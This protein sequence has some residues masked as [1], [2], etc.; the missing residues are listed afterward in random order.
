MAKFG[1][2][3]PVRRVEDVR[4]ITGHG[5]YTDDVHLDGETHAVMVRAQ[6]AHAKITSVDIAAAKDAPGVLAVVTGADLEAD[7]ANSV[8]CIVP[9]ENQDG[10]KAAMPNRPVLAT[11]K[12]RYVGDA[13]AMVVAETA[14]QARD[15]AEL[16]VVDTET[17]PAVADTAQAEKAKS[18][19]HDDAPGNLAF[20]WAA[21]DGDAMDGIFKEAKHV[22]TLDLVNNRLVPHSMEPR[23]AIADWDKKAEKL[24]FYANT[25]GGWSIKDFLAKQILKVDG[26]KVRV[27]TPD[28]GGGFGMKIF[29]YPEHGALAWA[30]RKLGRPIRWIPE[31]SDAFLSDTQ[32]RDHLTRV[33]LAFN[34]DHEITGLRVRTTANLGAY[35]SMFAP[36]IPT[37][38]ALKVLPGVYDVKA[39]HYQVRGVFTNTVPVDAYRGAGRPESI[40]MMERVID[41]AAR[42]LKLDPAELRRRNFIKPSA[43][44]FK[45]AAGEEYD[46]GDFAK[47]MDSALANADWKGFSKR[48]AASEKAGKRRGIGMCYYIESTMGS[49]DE[50][51]VINF[52]DDDTVEILVGTQSN[53]QG[54]ETA[55]VQI[56][57]EK[58]GIP[59]ENMRVVQGDTDRIPSGGGT[60]GSRSVTAEGWALLEASDQVIERGKAAA[61]QIMEAA[62]SDIEFGDGQFRIAGTDRAMG[63]LELARQARSG[64]EHSLDADAAIEVKKWTFPNGCHIAEVEIDPETGVTTVARYTVVDD[65]GKLINPLLV[66]GQVHGGVVQG[67]GQALLE[68][69]VYDQD[70]Q[71]LSGSLMDY[72]L[73]RADDTPSIGFSTVEVPCLNN[74]LGMKGCG[75]AGAVGSPGAIINAMIDALGDLGIDAIDM[76]ATPESVWRTIRQAA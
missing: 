67:L 27:V 34:G 26:D 55:Y 12:V 37:M 25:Q 39:L 76:P 60:G 24:T 64:G 51:A 32:G 40:Y 30:A 42:E 62:A 66:A 38:A 52:L 23:A 10:S 33:E 29:Y 71:L 59:L 50:N 6:Q 11:D 58:L 46:T 43:M 19:V 49:G 72:C 7:D 65:F 21:G 8:P 63:I 54:H 74:P 61:A 45:T 70:G 3:Q 18:P 73:P 9:L 22:T 1:I 28:V 16:V 14:A 57:H 2:S 5:R 48:R 13:V 69:T 36:F 75:E 4:F 53:G 41:K 44:P 35:L 15:A 56:V 31:R 20:D 68:H 17:L 47:V